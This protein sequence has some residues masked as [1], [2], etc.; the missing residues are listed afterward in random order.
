LTPD[1]LANAAETGNAV[2]FEAGS[3]IRR[4]ESGTF[5]SCTSLKSICIPPWVE[6]IDKQCFVLHYPWSCSRVERIIFEP[7]SRL[8]EIA[9]EAFLRCDCL[10]RLSIPASVEKMTASS[11]PVL[12]GF[13]LEIEPGNQYFEKKD[14]FVKRSQEHHLVKY[15]GTAP[16]VAI[17]DNIETIG[18]SCFLFCDSIRSVAFSSL[19]NLF[20]IEAHA[21]QGC[22]SL[23][24][25]TIPSSV[26]FLGE[27]C[28][29]GCLPLR[30][31]SFCPG[32]ALEAIPNRAFQ[33]CYMLESIVVPSSVKILGEFCF[34]ECASLENSPL[35]ADSEVVRIE[36]AAFSDCFSLKS[37]ILPSSTQFVGESCFLNC[38]GLLDFKFSS[39]A[40][41]RE[42]LDIPKFVKS[43]DIPDSV[44]VFALRAGS[45]YS[46]V[47]TF[48]FGRESRLMEL[49]ALPYRRRFP[50]R[51]FLQVSSRSVKLLRTSVEFKSF[52]SN[53]E[54]A[55]S[56]GTWD[57]VG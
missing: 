27:C 50:T 36:N 25:I 49:R 24:A 20:S 2:R 42:L 31:V 8:R 1:F 3:Q 4:L 53:E 33:E 6:F 10:K 13:R 9:P 37:M 12:A 39:P 55:P 47:Q 48:L 7:G 46:N 26:R 44:E 11:F 28:F 22:V 57:R 18:E 51:S 54:R 41:L 38:D 23:K 29:G 15:V 19:S 45:G 40:N 17:P 14:D 34:C 5:A 32:S 56:P 52:G 21:F 16:R 30:T 43:K 35:P